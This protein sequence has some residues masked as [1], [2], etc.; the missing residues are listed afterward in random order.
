[1]VCVFHSYEYSKYTKLH[2]KFAYNGND[3]RNCFMISYV[4]LFH[5]LVLLYKLF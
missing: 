3:R 5:R 4:Q 1:M 2:T